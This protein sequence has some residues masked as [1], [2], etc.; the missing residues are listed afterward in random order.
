GSFGSTNSTSLFAGAT[1][2]SASKTT[3][4][5]PAQ[6]TGAASKANAG[7]FTIFMV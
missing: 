2:P 3:A 6:F 1:G 5:R 4:T 7:I